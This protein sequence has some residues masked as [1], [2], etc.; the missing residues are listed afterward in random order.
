MKKGKVQLQSE[1]C[2]CNQLG[3]Y[4]HAQSLQACPTLCDPMD[5]SLPGLL[6]QWDSPMQ[7][8]WS[9]LPCLPPGYLPDP[10]FEPA[11]SPSFSSLQAY[12]LPLSHPGSATR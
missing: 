11:A 1:C 9:G 8:Y 10:G 6:C 4:V 2:F 3:G 7:G 5:Y 12:S